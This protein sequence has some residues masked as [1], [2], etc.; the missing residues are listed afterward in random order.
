MIVIKENILR[1]GSSNTDAINKNQ[2][3]EPQ[4]D[5]TDH[6]IVRSDL[7][8]RKLFEDNA[9]YEIVDSVLQKGFPS[10]LFPVRMYMLRRRQ[11]DV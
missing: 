1:D 5:P 10:E 9:G 2:L 11:P 7:H 6:S 8:F 4:I 3:F